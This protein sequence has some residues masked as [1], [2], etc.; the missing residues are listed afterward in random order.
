MK[1]AFAI[2]FAL[3][4]VTAPTARSAPKEDSGRPAHGCDQAAEND[5]DAYDSTCDE[6]PSQNGNG[7]GKA[8]GKPCAGCVGAADNKNPQGQAPDGS[9]NNKG[10]EC[11]ENKG[12]GPSNPAH[13]GC[14]PYSNQALPRQNKKFDGSKVMDFRPELDT[15]GP[16]GAMLVVSTALLLLLVYGGSFFT[17][18]ARTSRPR[19]DAR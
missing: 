5:G 13:T 14:I 18:R 19:G 17:R 6:S 9:D 7:D 11:D 4:V 3:L 12:V 2:V 8:S 16:T 1:R 10:Y 15:T